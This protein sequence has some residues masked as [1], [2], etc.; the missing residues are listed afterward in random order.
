MEIFL[1]IFGSVL[2]LLVA[3][4]VLCLRGRT[5]HKGLQALRGWAYAHR[6]LHGNGVPENSMMAFQKALDNG[7]GIE[8]DIHLLA[9]GNLAVIHDS[10]LRRTAGFDINIEDLTTNDLGKYFLEGTGETIPTFRQVLDLYQGKAPLI[11]ELKA[12][13]GNHAA[14]CKAACDMLD[15]YEGAYCIESFDPRCVY[16]LCKNRPE[17]VRGQLAENF[18]KSKTSKLPWIIKFL[19]SFHFVNFLVKPDFISY[20]FSDRKVIGTRLCRKLWRL[21]GAT[22]TI[23]SKEDYDRAVETGWIPIFEGFDPNA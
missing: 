23:R 12:E 15:T 8:L 10:S 2:V 11:V 14:L 16:W 19:M 7:F 4:Y 5:G 20:R 17:I 6:G 18:F 22:W 9:D 3:L 21:Q 1:I 13:R